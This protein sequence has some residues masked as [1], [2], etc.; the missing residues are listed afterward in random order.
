MAS[1]PCLQDTGACVLL[2]L[3]FSS[4][5]TRCW[6]ARKHLEAL[7]A[8]D[9]CMSAHGQLNGT[10]GGMI[11]C[12][13]IVDGVCGKDSIGRFQFMLYPATVLLPVVKR[14]LPFLI[15]ITLHVP[16][17]DF[18]V[19]FCS[20]R[21]RHAS[22]CR[23]SWRQ[24]SHL[25]VSRLGSHFSSASWKC[26]QTACRPRPCHRFFCENPN[27]KIQRIL[28][29]PLSPSARCRS[30]QSRHSKGRDPEK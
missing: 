9:C 24:E 29:V 20:K 30:D 8:M 6:C 23:Y 14:F 17:H 18:S 10:H 11:R 21:C 15:A 5:E 27:R 3:V 7:P 28:S 1:P 12:W 13:S 22:A 2:F 25:C 26:T 4:G 19:L 16:T